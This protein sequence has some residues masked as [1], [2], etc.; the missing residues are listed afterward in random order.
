M[1]ERNRIDLS[2]VDPMDIGRWERLVTR[3]NAATRPELARR[4]RQ[5]GVLSL[6]SR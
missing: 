4:A 5:A 1:M 3:I 2:T 6:L